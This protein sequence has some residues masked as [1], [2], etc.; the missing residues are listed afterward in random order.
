MKN[1][2]ITSLFLFISFATSAQTLKFSYL[3]KYKRDPAKGW[4]KDYSLCVEIDSLGVLC[5][6]ENEYLR[7]SVGYEVID[8]GL[9]HYVAYEEENRYPRGVQWSVFGNPSTGK[10]T[11][12][13]YRVTLNFIAEDNYQTPQWEICDDTE[14][15]CGYLCRKAVSNYYGRLWTV[16]YTEEIPIGFGPW[17][18]WGTPGMVLKAEDSE[19][20]FCFTCESA[21]VTNFSR[22]SSVLSHITRCHSDNA[23]VIITGTMK[24]VETLRTKYNRDIQA[25]YDAMGFQVRGF[26]AN[27]NPLEIPKHRSYIPLIPDEYWK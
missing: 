13:D 4:N 6:S 2:I 7:D 25:S 5:Y 8:A 22:R 20:L 21:I 16:W 17:L 19:M 3:F 15:I 1:F 10:F 18:L 11:H 24:E 14:E 23:A 12:Y 9:D 27:G 26:D